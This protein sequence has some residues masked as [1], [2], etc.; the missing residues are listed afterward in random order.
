[1]RGGGELGEAW[2]LGG[3]DANK[4]HSWGDLIACAEDLIARGVTT[5]DKVFILGGSAGGITVG[6]ALTEHPDLFA[7]AD[8]NRLE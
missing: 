1:M 5:R 7:G 4:P 6:R 8:H 2:R 3:K